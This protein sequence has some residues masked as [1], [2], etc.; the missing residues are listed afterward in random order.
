MK[1]PL[2]E[3]GMRNMFLDYGGIMVAVNMQ[4]AR[5]STRAAFNCRL[6]VE[7]WGYLV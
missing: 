5:T 6:K 1:A 7:T 4:F 2:G 3:Q